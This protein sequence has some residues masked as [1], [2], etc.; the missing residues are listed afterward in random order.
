MSKKVA[1]IGAGP[2][3]L[4]AA[5]SLGKKLQSGSVVL[6]DKGVRRQ[7]VPSTCCLS[8]ARDC[9]LL[10]GFGGCVF[11]MFPQ[12][13]SFFPAGKR[14][15]KVLT[16]VQV[17]RIEAKLS[18]EFYGDSLSE[19]SYCQDRIGSLELSGGY[20]IGLLDSKA[21][22]DNLW[23]LLNGLPNGNLQ[24]RLN[25]EI[26]QIV[27][28]GERFLLTARCPETNSHYTEDF[29][30]IICG[31]GRGGMTWWNGIMQ[32]LCIA[33]GC[34][35]PFVGVRVQVPNV[36]LKVPAGMHPDLKLRECVKGR[37]FKTFCFCAS[38]GGGIVQKVLIDG[39]QSLDGHIASAH[40]GF[41]TGNF[42]ILGSVLVSEKEEILKRYDEFSNGCIVKEDLDSFL[43]DGV[44]RRIFSSD[45][46]SGI[47]FLLRKAAAGFAEVG[48]YQVDEFLNQAEIFG[49][50]QQ[51]FFC[52]VQL[53]SRFRTSVDGVY[54]VGDAAGLS[55]GINQAAISGWA[56]AED[57]LER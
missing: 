23:E 56:A 51:N 37:R 22:L 35:Y 2:S 34:A 25:T 39:M 9:R 48:G 6:F 11:P 7:N 45:I 54:A 1:I 44:L 36:L 55:Q 15:L 40:C 4:S 29:D 52:P 28:S 8:C 24:L 41:R 31:S 16:K 26:C 17:E 19:V 30:Y 43:G 18:E 20:R 5:V 47:V 57:I 42:S 53:G 38:D 33:R 49:V 12:K 3:G 13:V 27:K 46:W 50:E 32:S 21:F 10:V 14:L